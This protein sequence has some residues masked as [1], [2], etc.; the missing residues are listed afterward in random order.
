[1]VAVRLLTIRYGRGALLCRARLLGGVTLHASTLYVENSYIVLS[2][3]VGARWE[4][5]PLARRPP[6]ILPL[7]TAYCTAYSLQYGL[8][9]L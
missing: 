2:H 1:M 8:Y 7:T 9:F 5:V 4:L 6:A 3:L